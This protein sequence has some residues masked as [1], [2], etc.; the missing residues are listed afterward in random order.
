MRPRIALGGF[1]FAGIMT[2]LTLLAGWLGVAQEPGGYLF[3]VGL[4]SPRG[5][6]GVGGLVVAV[7][8]EDRPTHPR[9][10]TL[11]AERYGLL[12]ST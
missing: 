4:Q 3:A 2:A 8:C 7:P 1:L 10:F 11:D 5:A 6:P 12:A 9:H